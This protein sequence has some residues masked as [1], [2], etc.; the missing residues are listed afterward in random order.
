M[1][2][3]ERLVE[4]N[5]QRIFPDYSVAASIPSWLKGK[6]WKPRFLL[7]SDS[8]EMVLAIDII[9]SGSIPQFQY[10]TI[11]TRLLADHNNFR[12]IIVTL[13]ESY[14]ENPEIEQFCSEHKLGLKVVIPGI[15]VRTIVGIDLDP[16]LEVKEL[17]LEDGWFPRAILEKARN[18]TRLYFHKTIDKFIDSAEGLGNDRDRTL[19]LVRATIDELLCFHPVFRNSIKHFMKLEFFEKLLRLGDPESS[20]HVFHSFRVFL[21]GCPIINEFYDMFYGAHTRYCI[22]PVEEVRVEYSW[23]LTAIFHDIGRPKE[24]KVVSEFVAN[25][26]GDEYLEVSVT[27]DVD[28]RMWAE[29]HYLTTKKVLGSLGAYVAQGVTSGNWDGGALDDE[30]AKR[31]IHEWINLYDNLESHA[32]ISAFDFFADITRKCRAA[33]ER[34][35][36]PFVLTHAAPAALAILLHDW[37]KWPEQRKLKL[38]PVDGR[39]LPMAALLIYIDTW[40]NYK[41]R[42]ETDPLTYIKSYEVNTE[43]ASVQVVWGDSS[44][45]QQDALGYEAYRTALENL[46]YTLDIEYGMVGT[47]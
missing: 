33:N 18:L 17:P 5:I 40:D 9:P 3:V 36:R 47:I 43:G 15:G 22:G 11:V 26:L 42:S 12:V 27:I 6:H 14:E 24:K 8:R 37:K 41:R 39:I 35:N 38:I 10:S 4:R 29:E 46:G 31:I 16:D 7:E 44:K 32:I 13:E 20:D 1:N 2:Q 25:E 21:S 28:E 30:E 34:R 23:L 45:M 19:A